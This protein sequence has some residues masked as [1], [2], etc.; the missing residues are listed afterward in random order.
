M[1]GKQGEENMQTLDLSKVIRVYTGKPGCMCGCNGKY[2]DKQSSPRSVA[3]ITGKLQR[4]PN[5]QYDA[6][7]KCFYVHTK[8]RNLVAYVEKGE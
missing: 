5:T 6:L 1:V 4:N 3:I 7:A 2:E 8:T